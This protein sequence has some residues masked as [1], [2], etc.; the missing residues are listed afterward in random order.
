M[1]GTNVNVFGTIVNTVDVIF[2]N[3]TYVLYAFERN[4]PISFQPY[5]IFAKSQSPIVKLYIHHI[6]LSLNELIF[7]TDLHV[8]LPLFC[9]QISKEYFLKHEFY[10]LC[11]KE[12][13]PS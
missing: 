2:Q 8:I 3:I 5:D 4:I 11:K 13:T 7:I 6:F 1:Y 12:S 10:N 9:H